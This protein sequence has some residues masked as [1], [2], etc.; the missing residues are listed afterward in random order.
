MSG[1]GYFL[2]GK[3]NAVLRFTLIKLF[4]I[5]RYNTKL[6]WLFTMVNFF[7]YFGNK[8]LQKQKKYM[9]FQDIK[10]QQMII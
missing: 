9:Y 10:I 8:M 2:V 1:T 7:R 3:T 6:H 5:S 4:V